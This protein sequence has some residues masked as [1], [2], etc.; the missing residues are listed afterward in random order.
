[1]TVTAAVPKKILWKNNTFLILLISSLVLSIG[2]RI[3]DLLL[4]LLMYEITHSSVSMQ[5]MRTAELLPNLLFA[6]FIGVIVDRVN[7]KKWVL[8]MIGMQILLLFSLVWLVKSGVSV[9]AFYYLLG[10]MLMT[11]NYGY[12]N[13]QLSLTK[14]SVPNSQLTSANAKF[15]FADTFVG[16][17]GPAITGF[18][19][20]LA[21]LYDGLLIMAIMYTFSLIMLMR[22]P[23]AAE[24]AIQSAVSFKQD[25]REGWDFFRKNRPLW[26]MTVFVILM[27]ST[28]TVVSTSLIFFAKNDLQLPSSTLSLVLSSAGI[29]GLLGSL[30]INR[31]RSKY[32]LGVVFG[33]SGILSAV[34]FLGIYFAK[35]AAL[36]VPSLLLNGFAGVLYAIC[37]YS[38]RQEQTPSHLMGRIGGITGT[39]FRIGMPVTVYF[40]GWMIE[41]WGTGI[42]FLSAAVVNVLIFAAFRLTGLWKIA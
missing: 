29:G 20:L 37:V 9:M 12:F 16:I 3:Y 25:L 23:V 10:F 38:F 2:N 13:A 42:V 22:M 19:L 28:T 1:M 6:I 11:F 32:R 30:L 18:I 17:M 7:K 33:V 34:S 24:P 35:G 8:W 14:L 27:N 21:N 15:A 31:L 41:W 26:M 39:F 5:S 4:P 40:S 36:L